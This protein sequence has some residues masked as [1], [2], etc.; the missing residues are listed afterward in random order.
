MES[1]FLPP[2]VLETVEKIARL[3]TRRKETVAVA[4]SA[5]GGL[6]NAAL[7]SWPGA[8]AFYKGGSVSP[9]LW[10]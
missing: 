1:P 6:I 2:S 7:L 10:T 9:N 4:E 8:S 5:A 3:L